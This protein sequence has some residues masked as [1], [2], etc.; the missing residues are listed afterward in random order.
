M[1]RP[2]SQ[3]TSSTPMREPPAMTPEATGKVKVS[4]QSLRLFSTSQPS[5]PPMKKSRL[6]HWRS[7]SYGVPWNPSM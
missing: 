4:A 2:F 7:I 6:N 1:A 3:K 5:K